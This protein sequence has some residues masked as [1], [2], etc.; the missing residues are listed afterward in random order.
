MLEYFDDPCST[1]AAFRG[2][3]FR[4]GDLGRLREDGL[5]ELIGRRGDIVKGPH[6]EIISGREVEEAVRS[7]PEVLDAL[8]TV[9]GGSGH[10]DELIALVLPIPGIDLHEEWLSDLRTYLHV[11]LGSK[12]LPSKIQVCSSIPRHPT[13]KVQRDWLLEVLGDA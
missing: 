12:K 5:V 1:D 6:G 4:T 2:G 8:T 7:H 11:T 3:W 9:R 10:I 13:G